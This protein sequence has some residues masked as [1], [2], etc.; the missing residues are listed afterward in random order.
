MGSLGSSSD[1]MGSGGESVEA[2]LDIGVDRRDLAERRRIDAFHGQRLARGL[3]GFSGFIAGVSFGFESEGGS[4]VK[5][6]C[7]GVFIDFAQT[8]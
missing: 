2:A 8:D 6:A 1:L 3:V 7:F 5:R 4:D